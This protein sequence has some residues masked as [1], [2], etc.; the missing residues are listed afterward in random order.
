MF[1]FIDKI[2]QY[3]EDSY[4]KHKMNMAIDLH[5]VNFANENDE[6]DRVWKDKVTFKNDLITV[7]ESKGWDELRDL[8]IDTDIIT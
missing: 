1:K 7:A 2:K 8:L 5:F 4:W 3:K 6:Y